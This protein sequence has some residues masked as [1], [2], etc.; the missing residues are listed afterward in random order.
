[1]SLTLSEVADTVI[2][3]VEARIGRKAYGDTYVSVR[4]S[5]RWRAV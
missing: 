4:R 5:G 1:M 3:A 2:L